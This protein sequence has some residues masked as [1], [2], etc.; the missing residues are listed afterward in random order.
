M[1]MSSNSA[2]DFIVGY[3]SMIDTVSFVT[4]TYGGAGISPSVPAQK[5]Y[6]DRATGR[7]VT[8][9]H[10]WTLPNGMADY[11]LVLRGEIEL[12]HWPWACAICQEVFEAWERILEKH[13]I[14]PAR[15]RKRNPGRKKLWARV[16]TVQERVRMIA[17]LS[18]GMEVTE[19][20]PT[21]L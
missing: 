12:P 3:D 19:P 13:N 10:P 21:T 2:K 16:Q 20:C 4:G 11:I 8:A 18:E 5:T 15:H 9:I 1:S 17:Y 7:W 14:L 6:Y